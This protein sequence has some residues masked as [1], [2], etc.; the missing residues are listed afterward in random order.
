LIA[1]CDF[2][3]RG[4]GGL[5]DADEGS[6]SFLP[7]GPVVVREDLYQQINGS[8]VVKCAERDDDV[9]PEKPVRTTYRQEQ[10]NGDIGTQSRDLTRD[11]RALLPL[12]MAY[13]AHQIQRREL[14]LVCGR[15]RLRLSQRCDDVIR[16]RPIARQCTH[17][18]R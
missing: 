16:A 4:D 5:A 18:A 8:Y 9:T 10:Q 14:P 12:P 1:L 3:Q 11:T 13:L 6:D 15:E 2:L 17:Q 7:H